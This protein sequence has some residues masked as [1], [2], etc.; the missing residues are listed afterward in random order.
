VVE[1][2]IGPGFPPPVVELAAL[3]LRRQVRVNPSYWDA[4]LCC[5]TRLQPSQRSR[6]SP[7]T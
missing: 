5:R 2:I 7:V 3:D 1:R 4:A 6:S